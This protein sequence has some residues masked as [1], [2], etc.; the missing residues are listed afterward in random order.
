[1]ATVVVS[2][3][4]GF[5]GRAAVRTLLARGHTVRAVLES[6][7]SERA[8]K[9]LDASGA[10]ISDASL[11]DEASLVAAG[12]GADAW[13]HVPRGEHVFATRSEHNERTL[14][15]AENTLAAAQQAGVRRYVLIS[16]EQVSAGDYDRPYV[17]ESLAHASRFLSPWIEAIALAE[18]LVMAAT[19]THGTE[20]I[21]L[22]P[23]LVWGPDDD[24]T[25]PRWIRAAR[26]GSLFI[27][28]GGRT[29][30]PTT[31]V[32]NLADAIART[33]DAQP[34]GSG[35]FHV[36]D[37]ER[38]A[39]RTFV[40]KLLVTAGARAPRSRVPY[41]LAYLR[42]WWN[43]RQRHDTLWTRANVVRFGRTTV[44]NLEALRGELGYEPTS[45][46][47]G[48]KRVSAWAN[49]VGGADG[50]AAIDRG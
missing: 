39:S 18:A 13:V 28:G 30:M 41:R 15:P 45:I 1:V 46:D 36:T 27:V 19:G 25:L 4:S 35:V 48:L 17:T 23:A 32:D 22:R 24:E 37:D 14:I 3:A 16:T 10:T 2:G 11:H 29:L 33:I 47:A 5:A 21:V 50:I 34:G 38:I 20:T 40:Q 31:L 9:A 12:R 49:E 7:R 42:A 6:D 8:R 26:D 43:D 44:F